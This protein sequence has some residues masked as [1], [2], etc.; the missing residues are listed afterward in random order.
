[1]RRIGL[2]LSLLTALLPLPAV[3]A[4]ITVQPGQTLSDIAADYGVSVGYLMRMN[5]SAIPTL[6]K[7]AADSASRA[8]RSSQGQDGTGSNPAKA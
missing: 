6:W 2:A 5:A 7:L 8:L 4:T 3:A 1:M